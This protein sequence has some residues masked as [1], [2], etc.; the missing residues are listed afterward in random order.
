MSMTENTVLWKSTSSSS[1]SS[2]TTGLIT[3]ITGSTF[4]GSTLSINTK[5]NFKENGHVILQTATIY[6]NGNGGGGNGGIIGGQINNG[7]N[8]ITRCCIHLLKGIN[9]KRCV[10]ALV[11]VTA[12]TILGYNYYTP[13][14]T[15]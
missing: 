14:F 9:V 5:N 13:T 6:T 4:N 8:L 3:P 2:S 7:S 15:R 11:L 12:I 10:L 1:T